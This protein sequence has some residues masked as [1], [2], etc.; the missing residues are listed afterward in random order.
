M[1]QLA[2]DKVLAL[3]RA[4]LRRLPFL[5]G[6]FRGVVAVHILHLIA[7]WRGVLDEFLR[8]LVPGGV[9][10]LGAEQGGHSL[11]TNFYLQTAKSRGLPV[12]SLGAAGLVEPIIY[13]KQSR[14]DALSR[15]EPLSNRNIVWRR[16]AAV[17]ETLALLETR[18]YSPMRHLSE[19]EHR[20]LLAVTREHAIAVFG[21]VN[22]VETFQGEFYLYGAFKRFS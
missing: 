1:M 7:D 17:S 19:D 15:V 8:V 12:A 10:L 3:A 2:K 21:S 4:D 11:L 13:L 16:S 22:A 5:D 6:A 20:E 18:P 9:L 14:A